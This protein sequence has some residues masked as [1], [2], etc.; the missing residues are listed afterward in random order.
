[1]G[2]IV[3]KELSFL[4]VENVLRG[5]CMSDTANLSDIDLSYIELLP[6]RTVMSIFVFRP[7]ILGHDDQT[8]GNGVGGA[9]GSG[10][11]GDTA[12]GIVT[13]L[14]SVGGGG[15]G[16]TGGSGTGGVGANA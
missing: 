4:S 2:D 1:M 13:I 6:P 12:S 16:G 8:G 5:I 3:N 10:G 14:D 11:S 7:G 15:T 9:G